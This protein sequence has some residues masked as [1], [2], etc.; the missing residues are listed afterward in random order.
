MTLLNAKLL[1]TRQGE[2]P[3]SSDSP[4]REGQRCGYQGS[5]RC[6]GQMAK[7]VTLSIIARSSTGH[8]ALATAKV[9]INEPPL[10][11]SVTVDPPVVRAGGTA[12]VTVVA[13]D[14]EGD[15][16]TF[17]LRVSEG[18]IEPT[19]EPNVFIWRA[20]DAHAESIV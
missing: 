8:V 15:P 14:P 17:N 11:E 6:A 7:T 3:K 9:F 18:R 1:S 5:T 2:Y 13:R 19:A 12:R 20:P 4:G 16:L 10:I